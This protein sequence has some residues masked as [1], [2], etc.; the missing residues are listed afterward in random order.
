M[1]GVILFWCW[2]AVEAVILA[3]ADAAAAYGVL[4]VDNPFWLV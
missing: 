1:N 3:A 2:V 4:F